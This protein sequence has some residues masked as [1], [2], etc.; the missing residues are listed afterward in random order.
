MAKVKPTKKTKALVKTKPTDIAPVDMFKLGR[1]FE[2]ME[3]EDIIVPYLKIGQP[4][5]PEVQEEGS[6]IKQGSLIN[7]LSKFDYGTSVKFIPLMFR[8]R[9]IYWIPR[10]EGGGMNCASLDSR[11]PDTGEMYAKECK[12]CVHKNWIANEPPAC[13]LIYGF[14]AI[15]LGVK[16]ENKLVIVSF[17]VT[18][19]KTGKEL[20]NK[21]RAAGGDMFGRPFEVS[22]LKETNDKG[23]YYVLRTKPAGK[24]SKN[25]AIEAEGYYNLLQT[26]V[27]SYHE[28]ESDKDLDMPFD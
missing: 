3:G 8:K 2:E 13:T 16:T 4:L 17:A 19:F 20:V 22:T 1:G 25:E 15:V 27:V 7:S 24:L 18:S 23:V 9:R 10:D 28:E 21:L 5:S 26:S 11:R 14:P 12:F 6:K